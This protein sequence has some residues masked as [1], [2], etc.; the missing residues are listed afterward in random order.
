MARDHEL[1]FLK[2]GGS[3][4]TDKARPYTPRREVIARLGAEIQQALQAR[5]D[6][7][8]VLG[9]GSGS[10]GHQAAVLYGTR[11]GVHGTREWRG[12]AQVAAAAA[13]LNRLVADT[14]L[15]TGVP[16]F[17]VQPSASARCHDGHLAYL[18]VH[19][20]LEALQRDLVPL[21]YGDVALDDVHGGTIVSTEDLFVYLARQLRPGRVLLAVTTPGVLDRQQQP[22]PAVTPTTLPELRD[23]LSG[24]AGVDVTGGM[25]DKVEKMVALVEELPGLVVQVFSGLE[26]MLVRRGLEDPHLAPGTRIAAG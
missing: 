2:L 6:L 17:S 11:Q 18:D 8:L 15:E 1:V 5:P 22:L 13:R 7:R 24:S 21:V 3:L 4:I 16:A 12:F 20:I 19:P 25:A 9:H 26:P 14:L 23:A 10:F